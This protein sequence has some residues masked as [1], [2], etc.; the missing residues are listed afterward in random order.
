M[1]IESLL[2]F[3]SEQLFIILLEPFTP[4]CM[5]FIFNFSACFILIKLLLT[6]FFHLPAHIQCL[7]RY[8]LYFIVLIVLRSNEMAFMIFYLL[9]LIFLMLIKLNPLLE[10]IFDTCKL[11]NTVIRILNP[12]LL[13]QPPFFVLL[14]LQLGF[15]LCLNFQRKLRCL[16]LVVYL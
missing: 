16:T 5:F 13:L 11:G 8:F 12:S 10:D 4:S 14:F 6:V 3:Y 15:L 2:I 9:F 1:Y 7:D